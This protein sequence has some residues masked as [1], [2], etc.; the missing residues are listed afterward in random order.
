[1]SFPISKLTLIF[2]AIL[3]VSTCSCQK[4]MNT[5]THHSPIVVAHRGGADLGMENSLSC[6]EKGIAAGADMVEIDI[7]LTAD[8]RL[9]CGLS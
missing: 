7:H 3:S 1:M 2:A 4:T 5:S 9:A 6:I 8:H